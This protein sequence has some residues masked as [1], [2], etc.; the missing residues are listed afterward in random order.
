[1]GFVPHEDPLA[2]EP[3]IFVSFLE[4]LESGFSPLA[5]AIWKK[6]SCTHGF[7]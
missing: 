2:Q 1:M 6:T 3:S 4:V 5:K 7:S